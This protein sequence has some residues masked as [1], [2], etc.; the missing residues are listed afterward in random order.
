MDAVRVAKYFLEKEFGLSE[1]QL[2]KLTYYAYSWYMVFNNKNKLFEE[3]PQA[4]VHG[5]VF[6]SL[7]NYMRNHDIYA[8]VLNQGEKLEEMKAQFLD[9]IYKVYGKYSGNELERLT[10]S[11]TP[12][13]NAR[14]GY[15]TW[16]RSTNYIK[17]EDII[18][19]YGSK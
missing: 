4:W 7:Y 15:S 18:E 14:E 5:P 19:Y 8:E 6:R 3:K 13:I 9:V 1:I 17:D 11:E 12:W 2:Q 16:E 10:H